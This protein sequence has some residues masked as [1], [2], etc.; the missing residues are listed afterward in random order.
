M[1]GFFCVVTHIAT[2]AHFSTKIPLR[3]STVYDSAQSATFS[4]RAGTGPALTRTYSSISVMECVVD[5]KPTLIDANKYQGCSYWSCTS[6]EPT[7]LI[8][9]ISLREIVPTLQ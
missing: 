4:A 9:L 6:N 3:P 2:K 7:L 8:E 5:S 1:Q